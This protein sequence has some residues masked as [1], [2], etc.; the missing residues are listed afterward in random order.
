MSVAVMEP[1]KRVS[2]TTKTM[3]TLK[4]GMGISSGQGEAR[5]FQARVLEVL[6]HGQYRFH[7]SVLRGRPVQIEVTAD[8][9]TLVSMR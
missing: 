8:F 2:Y 3:P 4:V 6:D 9:A 7:I 5:A 1:A